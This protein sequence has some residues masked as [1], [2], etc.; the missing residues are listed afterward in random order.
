MLLKIIGGSEVKS[1]F[2]IH[3]P[4][5]GLRQGK[6][7]LN[8]ENHLFCKQMDLIQQIVG[9]FMNIFRCATRGLETF[10]IKTSLFLFLY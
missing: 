7:V 2:K 10:A 8:N 5:E 6:S 4:T 9:F 3:Y 1:L